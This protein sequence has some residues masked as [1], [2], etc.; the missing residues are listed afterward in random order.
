M[1]NTLHNE[2]SVSGRGPHFITRVSIVT[3]TWNAQSHVKCYLDSLAPFFKDAADCEIIIVDNASTDGT[4]QFIQDNYPNITLIENETNLGFAKATNMGIQLA[5]GEYICLINSDVQVLDN[6]I[7]KMVRYMDSNP[8]I[9]LLGPRMD[10]ITDSS[11]RSFMGEPTLWRLFCRALALD[12]LFPKCRFFGGFLMPFF[13]RS[14]ISDVD[15]LNGWFWMV[16]RQ[17]LVETGLLDES[18]FI[19]GE[20]IDWCKRFRSSGWRVVYYPAA[21]SIHYGGASSSVAPVRFYLERQ[22][23]NLRYWNKYHGRLSEKLY[24]LIILMEQLIRILGYS[25]AFVSSSPRRVNAAHKIK[26]AT[27]CIGWIV[28]RVCHTTN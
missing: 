25:I 26:A 1:N 28:A 4:A 17:A 12:T 22:R 27:A 7:D 16:R 18:F 11:G 13:D 23:A 5:C 21:S 10:G 8:T 9:G 3:V 19:Y 14:A 15:V 24:L 6:C 20:D 2:E